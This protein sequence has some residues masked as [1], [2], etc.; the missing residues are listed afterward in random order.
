MVINHTVSLVALG[1]FCAVM[2]A[3]IGIE[4]VNPPRLGEHDPVPQPPPAGQFLLPRAESKATERLTIAPIN[5]YDEI[6]ERPLFLATRRPP[7]V[8]PETTQKQS[9]SGE[10]LRLLGVVLTPQQTVALLQVDSNGKTARLKVGEKFEGWQL[11]SVSASKVALRRGEEM[12]NL[13]LFVPGQ[14][15]TAK[16]RAKPKMQKT[17]NKS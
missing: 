4:L 14:K 2:M 1:L 10:G 5:R 17:E 15:A 6:L 7:E 11:E 12:K 13:P 16:S 9:D 3:V 8:Q